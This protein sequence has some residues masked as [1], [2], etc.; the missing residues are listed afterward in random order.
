MP[1]T[2]RVLL[3]VYSAKTSLHIPSVIFESGLQVDAVMPIGHPMQK[4]QH[5]ARVY[6][7]TKQDWAA[8]I[9]ERLKSLDYAIFINC[10]MQGL[11]R[12]YKHSWPNKILRFLPLPKVIGITKAEQETWCLANDLPWDDSKNSEHTTVTGTAIFYTYQK[13][14]RAQYASENLLLLPN[15]LPIICKEAFR[16]EIRKYS[17][18]LAEKSQIEGFS[19]FNYSLSPSGVLS[20]TKLYIASIPPIIQLSRHFGINIGEVILFTAKRQKEFSETLRTASNTQ[21][22]YLPEAIQFCGQGGWKIL[23]PLAKASIVDEIQGDRLLFI[24][25]L[26]DALVLVCHYLLFYVILKLIGYFTKKKD[27]G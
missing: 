27:S 17:K 3:G 18:I 14:I 1:I 24:R 19:G 13:I 4:A 8:T 23:K 16:S 26:I 21:V 11:N 22:I 10:D 7:A 25:Q 2:L 9:E 5:L 15:G 20:I 12:I 6:Q